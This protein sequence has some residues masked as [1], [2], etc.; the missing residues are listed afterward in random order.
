[1][2]T[3]QLE[4]HLVRRTPVIRPPVKMP[5]VRMDLGQQVVRRAEQDVSH[6]L[7]GDVTS[8]QRAIGNRATMRLL[9]S[10]GTGRSMTV[11]PAHD[12]HEDQADRVARSLTGASRRQTPNSQVQRAPEPESSAPMGLDGGTLDSDTSQTIRRAQGGGRPIDAKTRGPLERSLNTDLSHAR[13]HI[14]SQADDLNQRLGAR[15]FTT[16]ADIFIQ[17]SEYQP[18]SRDGRTLLYHE[19]THVHQQT[20]GAGRSPLQGGGMDGD[21]KTNTKTT[22]GTVQRGVIQRDIS[23]KSDT[24]AG[25]WDQLYEDGKAKSQD[26]KQTALSY[27]SGFDT[28]EQDPQKRREQRLEEKQMKSLLHF[29]RKE[30]KTTNENRRIIFRSILTAERANGQSMAALAELKQFM[31]QQGDNVGDGN[32]IGLLNGKKGDIDFLIAEAR[33]AGATPN[34]LNLFYSHLPKA[35]ERLDAK[36]NKLRPAVNK[37]APEAVEVAST[38]DK[39]AVIRLRQ[40]SKQMTNLLASA[41]EARQRGEYLQTQ[42]LVK[43]LETLYETVWQ[44]TQYGKMGSKSGLSSDKEVDEGKRLGGG[45]VSKVY[46]VNYDP[47]SDTSLKHGVFKQESREYDIGESPAAEASGIPQTEAN[48]GGRSVATYKVD[49]LFGLGMT[50]KTKFGT[51]KGMGGT[52]QDWAKGQSPQKLTTSDSGPDKTHYRE[53]DYSDP[54]IQRQLATLQ[55]FDTITGQVD[56]HPGNYYIHQGPGGTQVTSIDNDLAFGSEKDVGQMEDQIWKDGRK[57]PFDHSRG[58][59]LFVDE[60]IAEQI[61]KTSSKDLKDTISGML[62][63]AEVTK[64]LSRFA[65]VKSELRHKKANTA[66]IKRLQT[67]L[68][69]MTKYEG[70]FTHSHP[71]VEDAL[72]TQIDH[73]RKELA[74]AYGQ[75]ALIDSSQWGELTAKYLTQEN[76]YFGVLMGQVEMHRSQDKM[77]P[78]E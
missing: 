4:S 36:L 72:G 66:R 13:L 44:L 50:P 52:V 70:K 23:D 46:E 34:L 65:K 10:P 69:V 45:Q 19:L 41:T 75:G 61:L 5:D 67:K 43:D 3:S 15:A 47:L 62:S 26:A 21:G 76:S 14:N 22:P 31:I 64:T 9:K 55:L 73:Y 54:E 57:L 40:L 6:L 35:F 68:D 58:V 59:P 71:D 38:S 17:R 8:L 20:G 30:T 78:V 33:K 24:F 16:G 49:K 48:F 29:R 56:R 42:Q 28:K 60:S 51:H 7:P 18:N 1:M 37:L 53:F 27:L 32:Y 11:G 25:L 74:K 12:R 2:R 63:E 77:I 39:T